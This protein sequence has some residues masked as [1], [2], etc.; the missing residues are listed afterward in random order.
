MVWFAEM[1]PAEPQHDG[2]PLSVFLRNQTYG[3]VRIDRAAKEAI[4]DMGSNAVPYLVEVLE[5][6]ESR[7][8]IA[9]RDLA[10]RHKLWRSSSPPLTTRQNDA[11]LA[12]EVL[13]PTAAPAAPALRRLV[14]DP[15]LAPAAIAALAQIGPENLPVLTNALQTGIDTA[16]IHAAGHLRHLRPAER[17][18][19]ALVNALRDTNALVRSRA[20]ESLGT[21]RDHPTLAVP[22][23]VACLDDKSPPVRCSAAQSLGWIGPEAS[24][25]T[26]KLLQRFQES[27]D[28]MSGRRFAEALKAI[29]PEAAESAGVK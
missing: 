20:A 11:A 4:R 14:N 13:G 9:L 12:C 19:P 24:A 29:R 15:V 2:Q 25:A 7:W 8:R 17:V 3:D 10:E 1:K 28:P 23:L 5:A 18:I 16:R 21:F 26:P 22:A 6:R 27:K